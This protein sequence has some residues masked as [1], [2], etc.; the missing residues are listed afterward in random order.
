ML[1]LVYGNV[2]GLGQEVYDNYNIT[3]L[4]Q[5]LQAIKADCFLGTEAGINWSLMPPEGQLAHW[6]RDDR[7]M[8]SVAAHNTHEKFGRLQAGGTFMIS[9]GSLADR[10]VETGQDPTGLG[11]WVWM[12]CR[13]QEGIVTRI[14]VFYR[15][16]YRKS[17]KNHMS[18]YQ[19]QV[20]ALRKLGRE[21]RPRETCLEDLLS[22][23]TRWTTAR[24]SSSLWRSQRGHHERE[25]FYSI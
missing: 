2:H 21:A 6:F 24:E 11:R 7:M 17:S 1:R 16:V 22:E 23:V 20:R 10:V 3:N 15:P 4:R 9:F 19:Q 8:R 25:D 18:V 14:A 12:K 13:G 5:W